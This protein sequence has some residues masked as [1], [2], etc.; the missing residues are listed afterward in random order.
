[1]KNVLETSRMDELKTQISDLEAK[2]VGNTQA[3]EHKDKG[4]LKSEAT[5]R[6]LWDNIENSIFFR[7]APEGE[8]RKKGPGKLH[9]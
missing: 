6:N 4:I 1:M 9:E 7:E 5:I 2:A 8:E 3:E